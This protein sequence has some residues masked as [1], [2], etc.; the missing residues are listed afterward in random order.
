MNKLIDKKEIQHWINIWSK[1]KGPRAEAVVKIWKKY[2][3]HRS[4]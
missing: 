2:L 4:L 3:E 1:L